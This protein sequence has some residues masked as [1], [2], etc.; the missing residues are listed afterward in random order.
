MPITHGTEELEA[1]TV[2]DILRRANSHVT[3]AKVK[4]EDPMYVEM[5]EMNDNLCRMSRGVTLL[6]DT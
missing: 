5:E 2:I 1:V 4:N 6:A 3:V